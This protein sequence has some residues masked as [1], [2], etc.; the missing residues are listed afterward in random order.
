[1]HMV[2]APIRTSRFDVGEARQSCAV[3]AYDLRPPVLDSLVVENCLVGIQ[4]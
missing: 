1:M 4:V 3:L 2:T